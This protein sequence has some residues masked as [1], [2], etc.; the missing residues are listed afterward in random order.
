MRNILISQKVFLDKHNQINW[1]LENTW[2]KYFNKKKINLIPLNSNHTNKNK[3]LNLQPQAI[4]ISGGNNLNDI[5][6]SKENLIRDKYETKIIKFAIKNKVPILAICRGFQLI[7]KLFKSK[8]IRANKHVRVIHTLRISK[9]ICGVKVKTLKVNSYHNY[10]VKNLP[11]IFDLIVRHTDQTIEIAKSRKLNILCL[12]FHPERK[13]I[14]QKDINKI[15]FSHLK[16]K[17]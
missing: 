11:K 6:K 1:S 5:E 8:I 10:A 14:S 4:I 17:L 9:K 16:I 12:M 2:Y 15:V 7:A 3:L 13:N